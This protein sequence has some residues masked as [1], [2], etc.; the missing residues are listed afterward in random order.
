MGRGIVGRE[1]AWGAIRASVPLFT[2]RNPSIPVL[3][4]FD[5]NESG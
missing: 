4:L 2:E 3:A 5:G 1:V